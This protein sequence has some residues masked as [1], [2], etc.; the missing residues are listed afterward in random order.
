[1]IKT[2]LSAAA[3][4]LAGPA[5]AQSGP[6]QP[7]TQTVTTPVV[8]PGT[9]VAKVAPGTFVVTPVPG[10]AASTRV[11]V[12]KFSDYDLNGNGMYNP[13]EFAQALY[14][15]ATTDPVAGNPKLP[16]MDMTV[17]RGAPQKMN[18]FAATALLNATA[19]EFAKVDLDRNWR[20]SPAELAA[21]AL[22]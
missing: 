13:M 15:M 14:F 19:D 5:V 1:M 11:K 7:D 10:I 9:A 3:L 8:P 6:L 22:M 17:H 18:P 16:A 2:A 21:A 20:V 4:C 12:Q